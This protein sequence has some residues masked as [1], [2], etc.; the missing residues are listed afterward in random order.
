MFTATLIVALILLGLYFLP[1]I[2]IKDDKF[3]M[4]VLNL[5]VGWTVVGWIILLAVSLGAFRR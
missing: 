5:C 2:L 3:I 4:F 1:T